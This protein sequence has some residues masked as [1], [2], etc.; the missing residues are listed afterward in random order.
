MLSL[1]TLQQVE[2]WLIAV[3]II[4]SA[5]LLIYLFKNWG[6]LSKE[7]VAFGNRMAS[8]IEIDRNVITGGK[9]GKVVDIVGQ[10]AVVELKD[11]KGNP[12]TVRRSLDRLQVVS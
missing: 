6:R 8:S 1:E 4:A 2:P 9:V 7:E 3:L 11:R 5:G 10:K 12:F